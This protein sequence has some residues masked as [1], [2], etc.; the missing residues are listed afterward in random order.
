MKKR[1]L[2]VDEDELILYAL[3]KALQDDGCEVKT[4]ASV[5]AAIDNLVHRSPYDMCFLD[6]GLAKFYGREIIEK[7][8]DVSPDIKIVIMTADHLSPDHVEENFIE[9]ISGNGSCHIIPKPFDLYDVREMAKEVLAGNG[10]F[11]NVRQG[12]SKDFEKKSRRHP[13]TP[14][15]E[16]IFFQTSIIHE[17]VNARLSVEAEAVDI[18]D[19][20]I[21][22]LTAYPLRESQVISFDEKL[23]KKIGVVTWSKMVDDVNCRVGARFA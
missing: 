11:I 5:N 1:I 23:G 8:R 18:S 2:V 9:T 22:F 7:M 20:G 17:G 19:S 6:M 14:W 16:K 12:S 3:T 10:D 15:K 13:R 4:A 21:G